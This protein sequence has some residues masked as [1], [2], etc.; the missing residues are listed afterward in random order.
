M[1]A[2]TNPTIARLAALCDESGLTRTEIAERMGT[3]QGNVSRLITGES[4]PTIATVERL[5]EALGYRLAFEP[6]ED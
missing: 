2:T 4:N 1:P 3:S 6:V 5:L